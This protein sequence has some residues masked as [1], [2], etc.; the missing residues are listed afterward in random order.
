MA[1][2]T[3]RTKYI[4]SLVD[5]KENL[6]K[7]LRESTEESISSLLD[8]S[9]N[10]TL[11]QMLSE[12]DDDSFEV[13]EVEPK[14]SEFEAETDGNDGD[15]VGQEDGGE[16]SVCGPDGCDGDGASEG[17]EVW[18]YM[19]DCRDEDGEYDLRGK[20]INTVIQ[21]IQNMDPDDGVR[22]VK[23]DDGTAT[24]EPEGDEEEFVID[25]ED[26]GD[27][28]N[29]FEDDVM[30][31][32]D[33]MD[34][35]D[36]DESGDYID[37]VDID[38]I[39]TDD[40]E[41][42]FEIEMDGNEDEDDYDELDEGTLP[43]T[44]NYQNKTA[45][46]MPSDNGDGDG[47]FNKGSVF[48][49]GA[50]KGGKNNKKRWVGHDGQNGG[51]AYSRR[52]D[53]EY[54]D[55]ADEGDGEQ[56]FEV[57]LDGDGFGG[58]D[59]EDVFE[60]HTRG[61]ARKHNSVGRTEVPNTNVQSDEEDTRNIFVGAD[62]RRNCSRA[63][64]E[65]KIA[66]IR[67]KANSILAENAELRKIAAQIKDKLNEAVVINSSLAKVI[68]LVTENS[69]TRDE[70]INILNRFNR[71]QTLKESREL[72]SQISNE[73]RNAHSVNNGGGLLNQ[74]LTEVKGQNKNMIVETNLLNQSDDLKQILDLQER[75]S[76]I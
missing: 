5:D 3:V 37:D 51:N 9:V 50:P 2:K 15:T 46:T 68:R 44:D 70:K 55:F 13:E 32:E 47:A 11:R 25:I 62:Q 60:T 36:D 69:T 29:S 7:S 75:L 34:H 41:N 23:N 30:D 24:V 16:K 18:D 43:Y 1:K 66:N 72:Y 8:E 58:Y 27:K 57:E 40:D 45:M 74:Q 63:T 6:A 17:D 59:D 76:R 42:V 54:D 35:G 52:V 56:I 48:D 61:M 21:L 33:G 71:V 4:K 38:G 20:D 49:G 39:D 22:I 64:N 26:G 19:E 12:S 73:L 10:R 14:D 67:R 53:E 65:S 28:P 31:G